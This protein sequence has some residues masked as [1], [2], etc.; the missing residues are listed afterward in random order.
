MTMIGTGSLIKML[1]ADRE[2][3]TATLF[4]SKDEVIRVSR[5][6]VYRARARS[7]SFVVSIGK[8]NYQGRME[9]KKR[10]KRGEQIEGLVVTTN[11]PKKKP[12]KVAS[13]V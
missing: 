11:W 9:V 7:Y 13:K 10:T 12:K 8:P 4:I 1:Q 3:R 5:N 2:L 6:H